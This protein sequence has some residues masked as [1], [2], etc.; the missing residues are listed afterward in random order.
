MFLRWGKYKNAEIQ[1]KGKDT[2]Y[3][4]AT[5]ARYGLVKLGSSTQLSGITNASS[6]PETS[7]VYPVQA[8]SDGNLGVRVPWT[9]NQALPK[10]LLAVANANNSN[11]HTVV[12]SGPVYINTYDVTEGVPSHNN[13][14][15]IEGTDG[16]SVTAENGG[17]IKISGHEKPANLGGKSGEGLLVPTPV[18]TDTEKYLKADGT[19]D[20]PTDT[21]V[22]YKSNGTDNVITSLNSGTGISFGFSNGKL[23]INGPASSREAK[24]GTGLTEDDTK[25]TTA[26]YLNLKTAT[27]DELGGVKVGA[28]GTGEISQG[29]ITVDGNSYTIY[30][31][32][33]N[34]KYYP[35]EVNTDSGVGGHAVVKIPDVPSPFYDDTADENKF[36]IQLEDYKIISY[37]DNLS[38]VFTGETSWENVAI[39]AFLNQVNSQI[40]ND[41]DKINTE[42]IFNDCLDSGTLQ[43]TEKKGLSITCP[44]NVLFAQ[45]DCEMGTYGI[46]MQTPIK[47]T[48]NAQ[49]KQQISIMNSCPNA[50]FESETSY[51]AY[52]RFTTADQL[53]TNNNIIS[54]GHTYNATVK[55]TYSSGMYGAAGTYTSDII[56]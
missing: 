3:G 7:K 13:A 45:L 44:S 36:S 6:S 54:K 11:S 46:N 51:I 56:F 8:T 48:K 23:T 20:T 50:G 26:R 31:P 53:D 17:K 52:L 10:T 5:D 22:T 14:I 55:I 30:A 24:A 37:M 16:V 49:G 38:T 28:F 29:T 27:T 15:S 12:N 35:V 41:S 21:Q 42:A 32:P 34:G 40:E 43:V 47:S 25:I 4:A 18:S 39:Q 9:D 33:A 19:W 2:T 1:F